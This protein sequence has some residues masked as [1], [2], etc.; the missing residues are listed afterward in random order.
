MVNGTGG[1]TVAGAFD[2]L[3]DIADVCEAHGL[4]FHVDMCW[5]GAVILSNK[6]KHLL[7]GLHRYKHRF[8]FAL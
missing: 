1:T 6:H 2:P 8:L 3:D 4:W 7:K 5:G